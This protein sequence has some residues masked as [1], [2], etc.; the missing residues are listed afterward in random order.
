MTLQR[1]VVNTSREHSSQLHGCHQDTHDATVLSFVTSGFEC[2]TQHGTQESRLSQDT[3][4][5]KLGHA[6]VRGQVTRGAC[7]CRRVPMTVFLVARET[8][9][10]ERREWVVAS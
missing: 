9:K 6:A 5:R 3:S 1:R 8:R 4:T 2:I 10:A 7:Q